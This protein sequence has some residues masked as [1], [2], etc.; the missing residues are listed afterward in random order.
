[1]KD[2]HLYSKESG[3]SYKNLSES[4]EATGNYAKALQS[5][6]QAYAINDSV[7]SRDNV[8]KATEMSMNY[9]FDKKE[10]VAKARQETLDAIAETK[11][12]ALIC[13]PR[14]AH[15][16]GCC[17]GVCIPAK[18]KNKYTIKRTESR[19]AKNT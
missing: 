1:M 5:L 7:R 9:E 12:S 18:T 8:R 14:A 19:T 13:K 11:Q 3:V 2:A 16:G 6:K 15:W 10:Q 17:S 4:Y